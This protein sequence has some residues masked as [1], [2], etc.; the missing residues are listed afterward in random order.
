MTTTTATATADA[1]PAA[2]DAARGDAR[3][4]GA[5]TQLRQLLGS[6]EA[7]DPQ[8]SPVTVA[9]QLRAIASQLEAPEQE[10]GKQLP[11]GAGASTA[12]A[13]AAPAA[14]APAAPAAPAAGHNGQACTVSP[15]GVFSTSSCLGRRPAGAASRAVCILSS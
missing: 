8:W 15:E 9:G 10:C 1:V 14:P 7:A 5:C 4:A 6:L 11:A 13:A 3:R 2:A 12:A